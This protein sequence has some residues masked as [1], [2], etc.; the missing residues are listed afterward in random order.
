MKSR[1]QQYPDSGEVISIYF[2][3]DYIGK[4]YGRK[5]LDVVMKALTKKGFTEVFLWVLKE[6]SKA[7]VFY[8]SYGFK[9][10]DDCIGENP[11]REVRYVYW[12]E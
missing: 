9:C 10:A 12:F 4:G 3:P 11:L 6:N 2:L 5:L 7:R 8:E 1:F